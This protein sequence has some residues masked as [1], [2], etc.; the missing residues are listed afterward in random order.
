LSYS[1]S[2]E[3]QRVN[4]GLSPTTLKLPRICQTSCGQGMPSWPISMS[5][6]RFGRLETTSRTRQQFRCKVL[7]TRQVSLRLSQ[8]NEEHE[9]Q[10]VA[11][12]R[13]RLIKALR[14]PPPLT[15]I[16]FHQRAFGISCAESLCYFSSDVSYSC[17]FHG[18]QEVARLIVIIVNIPYTPATSAKSLQIPC[19]T[20]C[21]FPSHDFSP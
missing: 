3:V 5:C 10:I 15:A 19:Q 12:D 4:R 21:L 13:D 9:W 6:M 1:H 8:Q 20:Y 17:S 11:R 16:R 2:T 18:Y 14:Y 7:G